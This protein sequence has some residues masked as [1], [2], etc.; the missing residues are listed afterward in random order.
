MSSESQGSSAS[1]HHLLLFARFPRAGSCKTRLIPRLGEQGSAIFCR[2]ALVDLLHLLSGLPIRK[3]WLYT[4]A[5]AGDDALQLLQSEGL[6]SA[7]NVQEQ[8]D[9]SQL[10]DRLKN[11]FELA[12]T[13]LP[14]GAAS[15]TFMGMDCFDLT[16]KHIMQAVE[17]TADNV[18]QVLPAR[19]GGY[20]LL[21][22]PATCP[23]S[24]FENVPW[25]CDETC[26]AQVARIREAGLDVSLG[27]ELDDVDDASDLDRLLHHRDEKR[28]AFPRLM[29]YLDTVVE[30]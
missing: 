30:Q 2:S 8:T 29:K 13:T 16:P 26:K 18:A 22:L 15:V 17:G 7:W 6:D 9:A 27:E 24:V 12:A 20:V 4:P 21:A 1:E 28:G 19:D 14:A 11:A 10:G 3:T 23:S 5:S 25:S